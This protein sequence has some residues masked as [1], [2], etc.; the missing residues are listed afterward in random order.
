MHCLIRKAFWVTLAATLAFSTNASAASF[1]GPAT[2]VDGDTLD[3]KTASKTV[4]IR[5]CGIDSP[6]ARHAGGAEATVKMANLIRD[7]RVHCIQVGGGTPCDGRSKPWNRN[8]V[9]AQ[10]FVNGADISK[11]MVC[12]GHAVDW[13][14]FSAGHYRCATNRQ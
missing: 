14:K 9:V 11:E 3:I 8:R 4:R 10:C 1:D 13:P 6:E 5:L 2:V 7:K 12:S